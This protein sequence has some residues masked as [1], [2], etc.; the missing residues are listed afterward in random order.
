MP[1]IALLDLRKP[2][3]GVKLLEVAEIFTGSQYTIR[4]FKDKITT[5]NWNIKLL[6]QVLFKM[7]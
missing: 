1:S 5:S 7:D 3:N 2:K 6:H 4:N